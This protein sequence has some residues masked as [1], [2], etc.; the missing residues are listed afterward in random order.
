M[1]LGSG[2]FDIQV[3]VIK[4]TLFSDLNYRKKKRMHTGITVGLTELSLE[5]FRFEEEDDHEYEI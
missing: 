3:L 4:E 2:R 1:R 5:T